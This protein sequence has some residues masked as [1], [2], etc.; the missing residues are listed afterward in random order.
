MCVFLPVAAVPALVRPDV[1]ER[2]ASRQLQLRGAGHDHVH[3]GADFS[4]LWAAHP[5]LPCLPRSR[6]HAP[7][8]RARC[9][10]VRKRS[11]ERGFFSHV[12]EPKLELSEAFIGIA[13]VNANSENCIRK[14]LIMTLHTANAHH[15]GLQSHWG[16]S[17]YR[18]IRNRNV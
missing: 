14:P 12:A 5:V 9:A 4:I 17:Q 13:F 8:A 10:G 16:E 3:G 18:H 7:A 11:I 1:G 6:R 2:R 15:T